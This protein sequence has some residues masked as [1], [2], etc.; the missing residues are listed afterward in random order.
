M[1]MKR[2]WRS[3]RTR[4]PQTSQR[5]EGWQGQI[6]FTLVE[7][8]AATALFAVLGFMLFQ[9]VRGAMDVQGRGERVADLQERADAVL[10]LLAE[11]LRHSWCGLGGAYEQDARFLC[12]LRPAILSPEGGEQWTTLLRF[13]RLLHE[14]RSLAWLRGAGDMPGAQGVASLAGIE[15]PRTL[16]PTGGLAE[17]LYTTALLPGETLPSLVRRVRTPLGGP[18][19]LLS[20][21]LA[22]QED[23]L[24]ENFLRLAEGV[25][26]FELAGWTPGTT[27]WDALDSDDRAASVVW[28]STRAL[29]PP[30][31]EAF[32]YGRH[33]DSLLDGRDDLFP[34]LVRITLVLD[35]FQGRGA[36]APGRLASAVSADAAQIE[37]RSTTWRGDDQAPDMLW[38]EGEWMKVRSREGRTYSVLRGMR[39]TQPQP[40]A[41]GEVVRVGEAFTR[42]VRLP[43]SRE[44]FDS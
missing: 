8:L 25:L 42:V 34:P 1:A 19:S 4:R 38:I 7:V 17:T 6:G 43:V 3:F 21:Q 2:A 33:A 11:D 16:Q 41:V 26:Y 24:L 13:T 18:G 22:M 44:D 23:R 35:P 29:V 30:G 28:D 5:V 39:G 20:P 12:S 37:L 31:D 36:G 9:L 10:E 15:D 14:A 32:P 27:M 40:H